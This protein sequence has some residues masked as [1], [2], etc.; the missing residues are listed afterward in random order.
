VTTDVL[1]R[2]ADEVSS[3]EFGCAK[4]RIR[5]HLLEAAG[6]GAALLLGLAV[7]FAEA[8]GN[9]ATHQPGGADNRLFLNVLLWDVEA[10]RQGKSWH[11]LWQLP[12]LYPEKNML[13]TSEHMLGEAVLF[14]P[15]YRLTGQPILAFNLL[16]VLVAV[17]NFLSAYLVARRLLRS[18]IP[19]LFCAVLFTFGSYRL[20]QILHLH[21]WVHF[22]TPLLF[23]AAVRMAERPGWSWPA[24]GGLCLAGQFYLAMILGYF[25]AVMI[26]LMLLTLAFYA[27]SLFADRRFWLRLGLAAAL[28]GVLLLPL[29]GPYHEAARRWGCW[30]WSNQIAM[31]MPAWH[32]FFTPGLEGDPTPY[33]LSIAAERA[34]YW[35]YVAWILFAVGAAAL[36]RQGGRQPEQLRYWS[37]ACLVLVVALCCLAVNQFRAY[38]FLYDMVPGFNGIRVPG[39]LALL[40]LWPCG[41]LGGWGLVRAGQ[42]LLPRA[43][44]RRAILCL[45]VVVLAFLENYHRLAVL[46]QYWTDVR[47]PKAEFYQEVIG[48]LQPGALVTVPLGPGTGAGAGDPYPVA[49][50][51]AAG[52]RPTLN[53]Y[54][55][56]V[57]P[58]WPTLIARAVELRKPEQAASLMGEF[59]LR[60]IRY[61]ILDKEELRPDQW[62]L[63]CLARTQD[64]R[65]WGQVVYEDAANRVVDLEATPPEA[66]LATDWACAGDKA[67]EVCRGKTSAGPGCIPAH[68]AVTFEP[69]M[70]LRPGRY[71]ARF[72][73][74][75]ES[76]V[77]GSCEIRRLFFTP[78]GDFQLDQARPPVRLASI[79]LR[80]EP[81]EHPIRLEF[82]VPDEGGPEPVLQFRVIHMN[83]GT[84]RVRKVVLTPAE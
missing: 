62:Q 18:P 24:V 33:S 73:L 74:Q 58:W 36:L 63:W 16:L 78:E 47:F 52:W 6:V 21:L 35:G 53:V 10:F 29:A 43:P 2:R 67:S 80:A 30:S 81:G 31:F 54:T 19:A 1:R 56:R 55:G 20:Y 72:D 57:P 39:R 38:R 60:G 11:E 51:I 48:K 25:A 84:L 44:R 5:G 26:G 9:W 83:G 77:E 7:V 28:A 65:A 42:A 76:A 23:L 40:A 37:V 4:G 3:S 82:A 22:P 34:T 32:N 59:R 50:A 61:L 69:S 41:L 79:P 15:F 66:C 64:H 17:L 68:G 45:G 12:N 46:Q 49:G 71:L 70:P 14:A 8:R 27:P 75:A 13:A